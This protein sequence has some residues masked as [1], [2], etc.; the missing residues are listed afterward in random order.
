MTA[1]ETQEPKFD[2]DVQLSNT[3]GNAFSIMSRVARALR[4][5]GA[6][7]DQLDEYLNESRSGD[8][9]HLLQTAMRWVQV[10]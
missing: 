6:T 10:S 8:Y 1:K 5:A 2:I 3:D 4:K 9:D 7:D